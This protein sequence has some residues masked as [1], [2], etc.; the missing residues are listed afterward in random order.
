[1]RRDATD[2]SAAHRTGLSYQ[3]TGVTSHAVLLHAFAFPVPLP[4]GARDTGGGVARS[5][6]RHV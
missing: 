6:I 3:L 4:V 5:L 1:M 2:G